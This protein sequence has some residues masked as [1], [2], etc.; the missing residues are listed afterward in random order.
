[1][2]G[3]GSGLRNEDGALSRFFY[4]RRCRMTKKGASKRC[5]TRCWCRPRFL[6]S[7]WRW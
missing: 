2:L 4:R 1:M 6:P 3:N 5:A 7:A